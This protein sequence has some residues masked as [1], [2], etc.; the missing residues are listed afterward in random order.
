MSISVKR[1][2]VW[3]TRVRNRPGEMARVLE[4]LARQDLQLVIGYQGRVVD[5]APIVG[6]AAT[7]AARRAG[8]EPRSTSAVLVEGDNRPP[9]S[10]LRCAHAA[11]GRM[12]DRQAVGPTDS[13]MRARLAW[14]S[15]GAWSG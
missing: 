10:L 2:V 13:T 7:A 3:R 9:A 5:V 15:G 14:H 8:F 11:C 12:D 6:R 4:P 1:L